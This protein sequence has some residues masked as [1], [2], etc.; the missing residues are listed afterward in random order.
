LVFLI[1]TEL[2]CMF[3]H[4]SDWYWN[5]LLTLRTKHVDSYQFFIASWLISVC[6]WVLLLSKNFIRHCS[7]RQS[8]VMYRNTCSIVPCAAHVETSKLSG[9][10]LKWIYIHEI[11][12]NTYMT[13][14][15]FPW[16]LAVPWLRQLVACLS[17]QRPGFD[18]RPAHAECLVDRV[19]M[20]QVFLQMF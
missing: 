15:W 16:Q 2:W 1:H 9:C 13:T 4:T 7:V 6:R 14:V 18:P 20:V 12:R 8:F 19:A 17:R 3:N 11:K 5:Y 10:L